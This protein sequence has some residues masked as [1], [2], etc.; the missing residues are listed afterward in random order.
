VKHRVLVLCDAVDRAGGTESYLARVLPGLANAGV[1][2]RVLAR[3]VVEPAAFGV[4]VEELSWAKDDQPSNGAAA[5]RLR[6]IIEGWAPAAVITSNVFDPAVMH[7]AR[8]VPNMLVRIHDHRMFCPQGDRSFPNFSGHCIAAM[9]TARCL[10]NAVLHGCAAGPQPKTLRLLRARQALQRTVLAADYLIASSKF[11]MRL[12]ATNGVAP[13]RIA[14]MPPPIEGEVLASAA[15]RPRRARVLFA[16]RFV[17]DKGLESLIRALAR[18]P[19]NERP[20]LAAAG[21]PTAE[22][23]RWPA[24]ATKLGVSLSLL[25]HLDGRALDA[26]IDASTLVAVPSLWPEPFGLVGIEAQARGRPVVAYDVGG[27]AEW[28]GEAG[29][30]VPR[31]NERALAGAISS[32]SDERRW[33]AFSAAALRQAAHYSV[34]AH[35]ERLLK[36]SRHPQKE[37]HIICA[38]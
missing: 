22:S 37:S 35:V 17:R 2:M 20:V 16:G 36:L 14:L 23:V 13:E 24:L 31:G 15:P 8:T 30:V 21:A 11:M 7:A 34:D 3:R 33:T 32:V 10:G 19:E 18:V 27:V 12:C 38:S 28:M 29:I 25:G 9:S 6:R 5:L 26:E 1:E 4:P